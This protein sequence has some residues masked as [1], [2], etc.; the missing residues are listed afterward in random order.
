MA[1]KDDLGRR[2]EDLAAEYLAGAGYR[3]ITRNWR[4][5]DGE[6]DIVAE[7]LGT[8]VFVEVKTRSGLGY[9]HPFEAVTSV[10]RARLRRL[11]IAWC[12]ENDGEFRP[13]R[14]DVVAV[15]MPAHRPPTLEHLRGMS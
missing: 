7:D 1:Q 2:G 5:A 10:K 4:C 3:I 6:I 14:I 8:T 13:I 9:G 11:A 12:H 15:V